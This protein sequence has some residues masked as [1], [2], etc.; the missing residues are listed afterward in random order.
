MSAIKALRRMFRIQY[1]SDLHLEY[2]H[3]KTVFPQLVTPCARYLALA[4]DI[5]K[6]DSHL[7]HTFLSYVSNNWEHVFYVPG[8]HEYHAKHPAKTWKHHP[9]AHFHET[10]AALREI[11]NA[12]KNIHFLDNK[13]PSYFCEEE[14]VAVV[15]STLWS[16]VPDER[17][18]DAKFEMIDYSH[19]P[20]AFGGAA[21][22]IRTLHPDD[23]NEFHACDRHVLGE[24]IEYWKRRGADVCMITHHMPSFS[25]ISP[26]YRRHRLNCCFASSCEYLMQPHVKAWIYGRTHNASLTAIHRTITACNAYGYPNESVPGFGRDVFLEFKTSSREEESGDIELKLAAAATEFM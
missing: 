26:R 13:T 24:Q 18:V 17:I 9:P 11:V 25:L 1:V 2:H 16:H 6:P 4:G 20:Y 8:S 23:T 21:S 15:G 12:Y 19:I 10:H 22:A 5:G 3:E 7:F 14:N